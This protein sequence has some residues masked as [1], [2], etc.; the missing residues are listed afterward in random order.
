MAIGGNGH[1]AQ[2]FR[3]DLVAKTTR[4]A[5]DRDHAFALDKAKNLCCLPVKKF[6]DFLHLE[7]V[8]A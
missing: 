2:K 6:S 7:V 4:T 1:F 5:M 3:A 8:V